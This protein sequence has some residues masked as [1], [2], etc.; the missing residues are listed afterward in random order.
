MKKFI[1]LL[2]L[3]GFVI[4]L[5]PSVSSALIISADFTGT[6]S[7]ANADEIT[8]FGTWVDNFTISWEITEENGIYTYNYSWDGIPNSDMS[9]LSH[10]IMSVTDGSEIEDFDN[11]SGDL[12]VIE[13]PVTFGDNGNPGITGNIFG[14][15]FGSEVDG[16]LSFT[17]F[18]D[19]VWGDFYA[20]DGQP[21]IAYNFNFGTMPTELT[22]D[23]SGWI[24][25]PDGGT[26]VVPEPTS[27]I[28]F[29]TGIVGAILRRKFS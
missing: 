2:I 19:P 28:L 7:A 12:G 16:S 22:T 1:G 10:W 4:F 13:G 3:M 5:N 26:P 23:F 17:T 14:I 9:E 24:A 20:K 27:M 11:F 29:G 6:R 18:K 21:N 25:R 8:A 15:K